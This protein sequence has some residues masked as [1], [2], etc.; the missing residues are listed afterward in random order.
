MT[1]EKSV[2]DSL[3]EK[4]D[5]WVDS[6]DSPAESKLRQKID[7]RIIPAACIIYLLCY[8][9]RA[10]IGNAR[11]LNHDTGDSLEDSLHLVGNQYTI[12]LM[13][14][15]IAYTIF[16][17]PSNIMLKKFRPSRWIAFLMFTWGALS[18][19]LAGT[20]NYASITAVRF[21]LG[22]A[23]AGLFPGFVYFLTFW[24]RPEERSLRV[25][26]I[27][28][29][30]TLAGAFGGAIAFGVGKLNRVNGLEGWRYLFLIEGAP[31]CAVAILV[32]FFFPDWPETAYWLSESERELAVSRLKGVASY[33][34][35]K[36]TKAEILNTLRDWRL[37][38]HYIVYM[39]ISVPFSSLS[40][41]SPTIVSGLGFEG[42]RA[43]LFTVPP[44]A[45]AYVFTVIV[46]FLSDHFNARSTFAMA[47]M[48]I[49]AISFLIQGILSDEAFVARYV[50]LCIASCGSFACVPPVLGWLSSNLHSTG[51]AGLAIAMSVSFGGP[52]QIIGVW[53]YKADEAPGYPTGH[54][55]NFAVLT[56]GT[57]VAAILRIM[58][59]RRNA[60][61]PEGARK[62]VL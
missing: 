25:A 52:G 12:A 11:L 59:I 60:R 20:T 48:L 36:V 1:L 5:V 24:Y 22:A 14:F 28:A 54:F 47:S 7:L 21:L 58:Y 56:F 53:I 61:L 34:H 17:T 49:A 9:D 27:L 4:S 40:L 43:Q 35:S 3:E 32:F 30:S 41:F 10:N 55:T 38:A 16:E 37:Y 13:V 46:S 45:C 8:L 33:G 57:V 62:W 29:S 44:Y 23:E 42:L 6:S 2:V 26:L 15:L 50:L 51:A 19:A 31:S 39:C 18:M